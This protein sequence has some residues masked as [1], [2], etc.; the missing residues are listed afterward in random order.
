MRNT[1]RV[2][3]FVDQLTSWFPWTV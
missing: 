2:N 1:N 3:K